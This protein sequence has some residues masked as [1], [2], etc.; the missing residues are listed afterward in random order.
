MGRSK[1]VSPFKRTS[2]SANFFPTSVGVAPITAMGCIQQLLNPHTRG[3]ACEAAPRTFPTL[4]EAART[5][6]TVSGYGIVNPKA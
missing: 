2:G 4:W 3:G 6:V 1:G 5:A